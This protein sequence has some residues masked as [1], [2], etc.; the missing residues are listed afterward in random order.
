[1]RMNPG[2]EWFG[3]I[4]IENS[5][6]INSSSDWFGLKTWF[7]IG[8]DSYVLLP[9]IKSDEGE[10]IFYRFSSNELQKVFRIGSE[11]FAL[12]RIQISEWIGIVLTGSEWIS[13]RYFLQSCIHKSLY[14]IQANTRINLHKKW[15]TFCE[16]TCP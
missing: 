5:V 11:W 12:V 10:S 9:R 2:S 1:M 15:I 6:S 14:L 16:K 4:L 3:L 8:S 13:I 7:R